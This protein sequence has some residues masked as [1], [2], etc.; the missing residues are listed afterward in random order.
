MTKSIFIATTE[1]YSGKSVVALGLVNMVLGKTSRIAYFKPIINIDPLD[2]KDNHIKTV[3]DYF[4][5]DLRYEDTYAYTRS[6]VMREMENEGNGDMMN[7][8]IR[9]FKKLEDQYDFTVVEGSDFIGE[10]TAFEF[11]L[12]ISIAKNLSAPVLAVSSGENKTTAEIVSSVL[13][14]LRNFHSREVQVLAV[15]INRVKPEQ[16]EDVRQL[17]ATTSNNG[18]IMAVIPEN[19]ALASPSMK[20]IFENLGGE[21]LAGEAQ[22]TN[23]VD[24]FVTGAMN[25]PNFLN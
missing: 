11:D 25:V 12:N 3:I 10:G 16:A 9:K 17:L 15:V 8:I 20:E 4:G 18:T 1:P 19:K 23:Q 5:L 14:L 24:H 22:L 7:T 21:L 2:G 13:N 6:N